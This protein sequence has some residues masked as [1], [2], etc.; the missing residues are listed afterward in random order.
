MRRRT[1]YAVRN[2]KTV[3]QQPGKDLKLFITVLRDRSA[4]KDSAKQPVGMNLFE[5]PSGETI[6]SV[7]PDWSCVN[8]S[9]KGR[10]YERT[11]AGSTSCAVDRVVSFISKR[12]RHR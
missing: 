10:H 3:P 7:P 4:S 6:F 1:A 2:Y 8:S 5:L 11:T 12:D 9:P